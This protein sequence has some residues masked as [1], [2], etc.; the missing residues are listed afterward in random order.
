MTSAVAGAAFGAFAPPVSISLSDQNI[1]NGAVGTA[2]ANYQI[3]SDGSVKDQDSGILESWLLGGGTSSNYEVRMTVV[4]G[5][6]ISG[7]T[8]SWLNCGTT[9][10]WSLTNSAQ[11][12]ST[13]T[14]VMTVE[15]RLAS[16]GVVQDTA[17]VTLSAESDNIF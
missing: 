2:T 1:F 11:N 8:G 14:C 4:S 13:S 12:N 15:I 16:S 9:R 3:N 10:T 17:T 6:L 7:T 5:S